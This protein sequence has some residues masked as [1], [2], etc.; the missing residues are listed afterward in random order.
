M[1]CINALF[2]FSTILFLSFCT[3]SGV[4]VLRGK[5]TISDGNTIVSANNEFELGFFSPGSCTN[6]YVGIWFKKISYG[7]TVW[8]A[9]RDAP[10]NNTSGILRIDNKAISLLDNASSTIIWSSNYSRFVNN[11]VAQLLDS[12][13]FVFRD[14]EDGGTENFVWQSF[15]YPGDT[16]LPG[17]KSG[18]GFADG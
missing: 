1:E 2:L 14:E 16:V 12:G 7:T 6:R 3:N 4:D 10:L 18:A 8:V 5:Q 17:M 15:D 9:N 11:P 13:N